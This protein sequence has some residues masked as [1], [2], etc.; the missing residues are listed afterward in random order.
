MTNWMRGRREG[1]NRVGSTASHW[2]MLMLPE[3]RRKGGSEE[4]G[5]G[6]GGEGREVVTEGRRISKDVHVGVMEEE[7]GILYM[8]M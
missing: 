2:L 6:R 7:R 5:E 1:G 8:Y 3:G 4:E